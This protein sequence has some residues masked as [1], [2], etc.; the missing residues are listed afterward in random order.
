MRRAVT[1]LVVMLSC[2]ACDAAA[3]KYTIHPKGR[4]VYLDDVIEIEFPASLTYRAS[5]RARNTPVSNLEVQFD[6]FEEGGK[7]FA[8]F[9]LEPALV[10][11]AS[12]GPVEILDD[13]GGERIVS[14]PRMEF[15]VHP[16]L[17]DGTTPVEEV[18][19]RQKAA[20]RFPS[21][22]RAEI[23]GDLSA[24]RPIVVR[25]VLYSETQVRVGNPPP[26]AFKEG[27]EYRVSFSGVSPSWT[28]VG[29]A[30]AWKQILSQAA[31]I[32]EE[33]GSLDVEPKWVRLVFDGQSRSALGYSAARRRALVP[34]IRVEARRTSEA[35]PIGSFEIDCP[36]EAQRTGAFRVAAR[37]RVR[38]DADI[39]D[40]TVR[41]GRTTHV[42]V[43]VGPPDLDFPSYTKGSVRTAGNFNLIA[44]P[45][46]RDRAEISLP[47]VTFD[48]FDPVKN[49]KASRSCQAT[50]LRILNNQYDDRRARPERKATVR[51][52]PFEATL[53]FYGAEALGAL[54]V[55]FAAL[56]LS[57]AI[58]RP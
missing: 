18:F 29:G 56:G 30:V 17:D 57:R 36:K 32:F 24:G 26:I 31:V 21:V 8:R 53:I 13:T 47:S 45:V 52:L 38:G 9:R 46:S 15:D 37:V 16:A 35:I 42:P 58:N 39:A 20:K 7:T 40:A 19:A 51:E 14:L 33:P 44:N 1:I 12:F 49:R 25:W 11:P 27:K 54:F 23:E 34:P 43:L 3:Q 6:Y 41:L 48:Y 22:V 55:L 28:N 10:G 50:V 4:A 5:D 2:L